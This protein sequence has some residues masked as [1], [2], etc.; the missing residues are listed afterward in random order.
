LGTELVPVNERVA[1]VERPVFL[2]SGAEELFGIFAEPSSRSNDL[3][4][5]YLMGGDQGSSCGRDQRVAK[6][7]RRLAT[8]G[9]PVLR[10]DYH[11]VG[12]S[13]GFVDRFRMDS[14]F[15][16]DAQAAIDWLVRQGLDRI[17]LIGSCF[18]ARNAVATASAVVDTAG[19][20]L[21]AMSVRDKEKDDAG[22]T[23]RVRSRSLWHYAYR[24]LQPRSLAAMASREQRATYRR[25]ARNRIHARRARGP[26]DWI[27]PSLM[28]QLGRIAKHGIPLLILRGTEDPTFDDFE[29]ALAGPLGDVVKGRHEE[30]DVRILH[31]RLGALSDPRVH[32]ETIDQIS[33][34]L[35]MIDVR[36]SAERA[37]T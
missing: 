29:L 16:D 27:S 6:L 22:V 17:V 15:V 4:V 18:G 34:W 11:G 35:S 19:I 8:D 30:A 37:R 31:G 2:R 28:E 7:C 25:L 12:D 9:H 3:A 13:T 26:L 32:E 1:Y 10:F 14:P 23:S 20:A 33:D 5:L 21:M 24:V 36:F